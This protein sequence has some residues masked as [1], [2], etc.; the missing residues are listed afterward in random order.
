VFAHSLSCRAQVFGP[1]DT[2]PENSLEASVGRGP[3]GS[4]VLGSPGLNQPITRDCLSML[5]YGQ[6]VLV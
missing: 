3:V 2:V 6:S 1:Q 4:S 5:W